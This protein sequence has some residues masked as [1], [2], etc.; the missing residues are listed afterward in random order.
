MIFFCL[1]DKWWIRKYKSILSYVLFVNCTT[2]RTSSNKFDLEKN[3]FIWAEDLNSTKIGVQC[4]QLNHAISQSHLSVWA[5]EW[6]RNGISCD[7]YSKILAS[8]LNHRQWSKIYKLPSLPTH[9]VIERDALRKGRKEMKTGKKR[10]KDE[11]NGMERKASKKLIS[12][13]KYIDILCRTLCTIS[14]TLVHP[15]WYDTIRCER[16]VSSSLFPW[17]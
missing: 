17:K 10:K 15:I 8:K 14:N 12:F 2:R 6:K 1:F 9:F 13:F 5:P 16:E 4:V 3:V 11:K 7:V